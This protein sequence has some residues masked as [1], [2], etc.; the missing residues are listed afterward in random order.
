[1]KPKQSVEGDTKADK[2]PSGNVAASKEKKEKESKAPAV[3]TPS[4]ATQKQEDNSGQKAS[5]SHNLK[6]ASIKSKLGEKAKS[7]LDPKE[8][9]KT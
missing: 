6:G 7:P 8:E 3:Q 9:A 2:S 1:M 4:A 5:L